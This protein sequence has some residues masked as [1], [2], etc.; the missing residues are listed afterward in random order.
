MLVFT[1]CINNYIPKARVLASTLKSFHP[2]WTFCLLLGEAPPADF[3]LD[4]EPFDRLMSF[5]ELAIPNYRSWLFRHRVVEICTAA[6]GPALHY[7]LTCEKHEKVMYLDP[8]IM[9]CNPLTPLETL[10][11]EHDFLLT[12][13][14]LTPQKTEQ[15]IKDNELTAL[16]YGVFNL[17]FV[18]AARRGDGLAFARWWRNRLLEYCYDDIPNG[19]F[20]DQ[21]WCDLAPA[22]FPNLHTV[23]DPGCNVASWNLPERAITQTEN[24]VFLANGSPLRFYHFTGFDSGIGDDMTAR[25]GG[26]VPAVRELWQ[27]YRERLAVSGQALLGKQRWAYTNFDDGTPITDAMRFL[28]RKQKNLQTTFPDPFRRPG[29]LEW[30]RARRWLPARIFGKIKNIVKKMCQI[31]DRHGGFPHGIPGALRQAIEWGRRWGMMGLLER[32][33]KS[34]PS[35]YVAEKLPSLRSALD[36]PDSPEY[37]SLVRLLDPANTPTCI[38]EHDWGGGAAYYCERRVRSLLSEGKTVIRLRYL[39]LAQRFEI[40]VCHGEEI[41]RFEPSDLNELNHARFPHITKIIVNELAGWYYNGGN[42][43]NMIAK[44]EAT[45]PT[46]I[47]VAD[48]HQANLEFLFHDFYALC[49]TVSLLTPQRRYCGVETDYGICGPCALRGQPF[50]MEK[51]RQTWEKLVERADEL[52]FF[53]ENTRKLVG[54]VFLLKDEKIQIRPHDVPKFDTT[55]DIPQDGPMRIAVVGNIQVHKGMDIVLDLAHLLEKRMPDAA[56]IVLGALDAPRV[57]ANVLV[58]GPYEHE[59]LPVLLEKHQATIGLFPSIWPETF[60][61]V[62]RELASLGLPL[63]SFDLGA[64]GEFVGTL[65]NG[66]LAK[67]ISAESA[68]DALLALDAATREAPRSTS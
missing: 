18:A 51:W 24:G 6:K 65:P 16:C 22:F 37:Q 5:D 13:H 1:S 53:S 8:D 56:I 9:V 35:V 43:Q 68:L 20:T 67:E 55:L 49:P 25:Y 23:R 66:R 4:E 52:V 59:E 2:D 21:R 48:H 10:L 28:Y 42:P 62:V 29:Y 44:L 45:I 34:A 7:F 36:A 15:S 3:H 64:Q 63:V 54:K 30:Y 47:Q 39:I 27:R 58:L 14:Q 46:L 11:D 50:S 19:L 33:W 41:L 57:P 12:P 17:G 40:A 31:L 60:S 38:L 26:N 61:F 32:I